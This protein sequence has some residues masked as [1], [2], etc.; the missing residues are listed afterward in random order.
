[1]PGRFATVRRFLTSPD[2]VHIECDSQTSRSVD[3]PDVGRRLQMFV[4]M[5]RAPCLA[6]L[7]IVLAT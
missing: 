2:S 4:S 7:R 3:A 6:A 1:M 5:C